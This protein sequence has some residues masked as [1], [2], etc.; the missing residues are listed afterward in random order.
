MVAK[1]WKKKLEEIKRQ[2]MTP[3]KA[4]G[5]NLEKALRCPCGASTDP[6][7]CDGLS[8]DLPPHSSCFYIIFFKGEAKVKLQLMSFHGYEEFE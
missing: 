4:P 3:V 6:R 5:N 2:A 8:S 1:E 7:I